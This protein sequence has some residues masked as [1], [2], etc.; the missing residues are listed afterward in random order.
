MGRTVALA[1]GAVA[2]TMATGVMSL[3]MEAGRRVTRFR[4]QPP[5]LIVRTLL[6]GH[7]GRTVSGEETLALLAHFG[8]GASCGALFGLLTHRNGSAGAELG[9]G[10]AL[11]LWLISY[12]GWVPAAGVMAPAQRDDRGRQLT[13]V[14]GHVVYGAVLSIVLRRL[15]HRDT[16]T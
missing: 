7:P 2:G 14:V 6:T 5:K 16:S 8:Y 15:R 11:L 13:L 9:V 3:V 12:A 4:R 1:R 10:Y